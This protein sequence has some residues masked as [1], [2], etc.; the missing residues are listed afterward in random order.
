MK[1]ETLDRIET[2]NA[3]AGRKP[4]VL[5]GARQTGKTWLMKE[6]AGKHYPDDTVYVN[7]MEDAPLC[8]SIESSSLSPGNLLPLVQARCGKRIVP[9]KTL[10]L[11]D[12]I[13][14]SPR[15]VTAL[16][17]FREELPELAVMAAGS[18]LGL[19]LRRGRGGAGGGGGGGEGMGSFPVGK[20]NFIDVRPMTFREFLLA[21]G[22]EVKVGE[23]ADGN[24]EILDLL[25]GDMVRLLRD[26]LFVGGMPECVE[27][28]SHRRDY[29]EIRGIQEEILEGYDMDF[30][31]HAEKVPVAKLRLLWKNIPA[32]LSK[33]NRKF[34]YKALREGARGRDYEE[35]LEWLAG[36]GMVHRLYKADPPRMPLSAYGDFP[37]FK[38]FM[39][40]V[41]LLG[42]MSGL[43]ASAILEGTA[44]FTNFKGALT[45]Q[46]VMQEL[47]AA[48]AKPFYW[49]AE[50]GDAEVDFVVQGDRAVYPIEAKASRNLKARS[51][52]VYREFFKPPVC[53]RTSLEKHSVGGN[54]RDFPLYAVS[55][56]VE[57]IASRS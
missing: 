19:K 8:E 20:V 48:G 38:L 11:L 42:A 43:P 10:L 12:E 39:H 13:Q 55:K 4:L 34:V 54:I 56:I 40:D 35:A 5:M 52:S 18:L 22:E 53:Y 9:G 37:A 16:K 17:F 2:W 33:E 32:Q 57:E 31:K 25:H 47:L 3:S 49:A 28:F 26:Y 15:A 1:R 36:A 30:A 29:N 14:E 21:M 50:K 44:V 51:L 6:F 24:W 23:L 46:Y 7:L 45:E 41:G 27:A